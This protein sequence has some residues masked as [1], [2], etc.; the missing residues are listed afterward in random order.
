MKIHNVKCYALRVPPRRIIGNSQRTFSAYHYV[1]TEVMADGLTGWGWTYTQGVGGNLVDR[2]LRDILIP[3]VMGR[4][5]W[6]IR[7]IWADWE[8]ATYSMGL[9]GVS[10]IAASAL[11]IALWDL[12]AKS[13]NRTLADLLGG[14]VRDRV[15]A[16]ASSINLN[17]PIESLAN[18]ARQFQ[19]AG[20]KYYKMKVGKADLE[21]DLDRIRKVQSAADTLQIMVDVN[22]RLTLAEA[23]RR[24]F[25]YARE[26]AW[27]VEEPIRADCWAGYREL[28]M[29]AHLILA[30]GESLYQPDLVELLAETGI[31]VIQPDLFR[32]GGITPL[33]ALIPRLEAK[34][35][36][37]MI[38]CGEEIAL[39]VASA[40]PAVTMVEHM[41]DISLHGVGLTDQ[42]IQEDGRGF[43]MVPRGVGHG[44]VFDPS[45]LTKFESIAT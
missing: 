7:Q 10:R 9:A 21:E 35:R 32:V 28:G 43:L 6:E 11:D 39:S 34:G 18:E 19:S 3:C 13:A 14:P 12:K 25:A 30:A 24:I 8:T 26:G 16:Y 4:D 2:I 23:K 1:V 33:I 44:I 42:P 17:F 37:V 15:L 40:F 27:L 38:H 5:P 45:I 31:S 20:Y 22:Q 41:P 36:Q 29:M